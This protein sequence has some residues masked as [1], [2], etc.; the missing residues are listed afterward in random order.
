MNDTFK[1]RLWDKLHKKMQTEDWFYLTPAGNIYEMS[2][3]GETHISRPNMSLMRYT[4]LKDKNGKLIYEGDI[5]KVNISNLFDWAVKET[6]YGVVVF[7]KDGFF[8]KFTE[9]GYGERLG[10][11][12]EFLEKHDKEIIGNIYEDENLLKDED[13]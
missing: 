5:F 13:N 11:I 1:F 3:Y 7:E 4:G 6:V 2:D 9:T 10:R 12:S 8:I